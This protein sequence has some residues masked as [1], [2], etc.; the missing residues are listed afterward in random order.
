MKMASRGGFVNALKIIFISVL[1]LFLILAN[2]TDSCSV[3]NCKLNSI[4]F[5][6]GIIWLALSLFITSISIIFRK[7][8]LLYYIFSPYIAIPIYILLMMGFHYINGTI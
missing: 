8:R 2:M 4:V 6:I 1:Y 5:E 7:K 3:D